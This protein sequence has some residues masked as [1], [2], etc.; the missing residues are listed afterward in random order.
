MKELHFFKVS[1]N[2]GAVQL[3][4]LSPRKQSLP[5]GVSKQQNF[6]LTAQHELCTHIKIY[7]PIQV[8]ILP[9]PWH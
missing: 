3:M 2:S 6:W 9:N 8:L 1:K 7:C 5:K 4:Q